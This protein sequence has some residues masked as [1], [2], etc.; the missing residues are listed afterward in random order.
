MYD[1]IYSHICLSF[2]LQ[3]CIIYN[4]TIMLLSNKKLKHFSCFW[5]EIWNFPSYIAIFRQ[6]YNDVCGALAG[7]RLVQYTD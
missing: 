2:F 5:R 7:N 4:A 1:I 3:S 6:I